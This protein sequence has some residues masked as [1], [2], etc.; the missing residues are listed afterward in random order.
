MMKYGGACTGM[1]WPDDVTL[2]SSLH[3]DANNSSA[4]KTAKDEPTAQPTTPNV[5]LPSSKT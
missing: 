3:P 2:I 5:R 4:T 1:I